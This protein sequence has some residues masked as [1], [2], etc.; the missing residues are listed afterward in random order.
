[1]KTF[2]SSFLL[3]ASKKAKNYLSF[4]ASLARAFQDKSIM[5]QLWMAREKAEFKK[6]S[7]KHL[8]VRTIDPS[9]KN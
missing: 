8:L 4:L 3:L 1:M 6:Q 2:V 5:D 9:K 7:E